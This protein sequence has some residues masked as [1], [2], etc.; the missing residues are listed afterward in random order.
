M[1][2]KYRV[3]NGTPQGSVINPLLFSIVINDVFSPVHYDIGGSLFADDGALWK[4]GKNVSH[5][6][7][8]IHGDLDYRTK[9]KNSDI[10]QKE[11]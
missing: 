7:Q 5:V 1:S 4:R 10:Y 11:N 6:K 8:K 3:D 9:N 2:R